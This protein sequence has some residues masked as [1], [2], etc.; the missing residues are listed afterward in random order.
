MLPACRRI[1]VRHP[2][3]KVISAAADFNK[4]TLVGEN[5]IITVNPTCPSPLVSP[6]SGTLMLAEFRFGYYTELRAG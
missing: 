5:E 3:K 1:I 2:F 6:V 4:V